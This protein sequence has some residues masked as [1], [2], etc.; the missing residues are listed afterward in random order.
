MMRRVRLPP[1][2]HRHHAI[3][4]RR[5]FRAAAAAD[6][7]AASPKARRHHAKPD[8]DAEKGMVHQAAE[9]QTRPRRPARSEELISHRWEHQEPGQNVCGQAER[10]R[11]H[12][13]P[14]RSSCGRQRLY[15]DACQYDA[16]RVVHRH[17]AA[18]LMRHCRC[19]R[20]VGMNELRSGDERVSTLTSKRGT[21]DSVDDTAVA[22]VALK[23]AR[24]PCQGREP[25]GPSEA[26]S[27]D[28]GEHE[29]P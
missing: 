29:P 14:R 4:R 26:R 5:R 2:D 11:E 10:E 22:I 25:A 8:A 7:S 20:D 3:G 9:E 6:S 13:V 24:S 15:V 21:L 23:L 28:A 19:V 16:D 17:G 1:S 18:H 27:L 12:Q